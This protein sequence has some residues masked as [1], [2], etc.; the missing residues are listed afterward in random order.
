MDPREFIA[1]AGQITEQG[2]PAARSAVS[3]AYYGAFHLAIEVLHEFESGPSAAGVAH[4]FVSNILQN[5]GVETARVAGSLLAN[6]RGDRVK[7]D[8]RLEDSLR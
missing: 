7:A 6:L 2:R 3:R 4:N 1:F 8:Y 5:I